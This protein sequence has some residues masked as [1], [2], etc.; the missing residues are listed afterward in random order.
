MR[1][2]LGCM[3]LFCAAVAVDLA[4]RL[5][6]PPPGRALLVGRIVDRGGHGLDGAQVELRGPTGGDPVRRLTASKEGG[7]AFRDLVP[8]DYLL[9]LP[10]ARGGSVG[11]A[12]RLWLRPWQ[13]E[14]VV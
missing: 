9:G 1:W 11:C 2:L 3:L 5:G 10:A 12:R 4:G 8:G 6:G 14:T 7:F 13:T